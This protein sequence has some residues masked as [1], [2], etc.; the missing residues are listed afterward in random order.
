MDS[1]ESKLPRVLLLL[2]VLAA[3]SL[4]RAQGV[5][6]AAPQQSSPPDRPGANPYVPGRVLVKFHEE[7]LGALPLSGR[8]EAERQL[9]DATV[10]DLAGAGVVQSASLLPVSLFQSGDQPDQL[11]VAA[12]MPRLYR[13]DLASGQDVLAAAAAL[14]RD[15]A[16]EYAEPDYLA[17]PAGAPNDPLYGNQWSLGSSGIQT[18]PAWSVAPGTAEIVIA[19][20]DSGLDLTHPDLA[21][22]L[23]VNPGEVPGNGKDDDLDGFVDDVR[24]WNFTA[25]NGGNNDV[26][27][28]TAA[29][30]HGT[31]VAGIAAARTNNGLGMAGICGNCRLMPVKVMTAAGAVAYSDLAAG[32]IYATAKGARVVNVSLGGYAASRTLQ[33]AVANASSHNVVVVGAAGNDNRN[34]AYYPAAYSEVIAIAGIDQA[35][36]RLATSNY[37]IWVDVAAPAGNILSTARNGLYSPGSGTSL[38]APFAAG[39]AG[40]LLS[41][42]GT[43]TPAQVQLQMIRTATSIDN[44][45]PAY[46]GNLGRGRLNAAAALTAAR[47]LLIHGGYAANGASGG[48]PDP[49]SQVEIAVALRND[50]APAAGVNATLTTLDTQ[51]SILNGSAAFGTILTG[52]TITN[53]VPF[54]ISIAAA[55]GHRRPIRF[56][57]DVTGN[58]GA[59]ATT[60]GFTVTTSSDV[61]PAPSVISA[62]TQWAGNYT[63]LAQGD[64]RV[65][66]GVRLTIQPGA[67]V[68]FAGNYAL[69][70]DGTLVADGTGAQPIVM[71]AAGNGAWQGVLFGDTSV[72]AVAGTAGTYQSGSLLRHVQ[73]KGATNGILCSDATPYLSNLAGDAGIACTMGSTDLWLLDSQITGDVSA[74]GRSH[75]RRTTI[76]HG[77]LS[78]GGSSE[79][80]DTTAGRNISVGNNSTLQNSVSGEGMAIN[81]NGTI[82]ACTASG[83]VTLTDGSVLSSTVTTGD[84]GVNDGTVR[85]NTVT[86]GKITLGSGNCIDNWVQGGEITV[87]SGGLI[88]GNTV[89]NAPSI[90]ITTSGEPTIV[91]N[92]VI[93]SGGMGMY[94]RKGL[95]QGNLIVDSVDIG[96]RISNSARVISNTITGSSGLAALYAGGVYPPQ[97]EGNNLELNRSQYDL[98]NASASTLDAPRNWWGTTDT[99]TIMQ[100]IYDYEDSSDWGRV[101]FTPTLT[102]PVQAAPPYLRGVTMTPSGPARLET[103]AFDVEF[104]RPVDS[105]RIPSVQIWRDVWQVFSSTNTSL[106]T[107]AVLSVAVDSQGQKWFGHATGEISQLRVDKSWQ[108]YLQ[109]QQLGAINCIAIDAAGNK[110]FGGND[111]RYARLSAAGAWQTGVIPGQNPPVGQIS[112]I[113]FDGLGNVWFGESG[114]PAGG[115]HVLRAAGSWQSYT[116]ANSGLADSSVEALAVDQAGNKWFGTTATGHG[117]SEL[118]A[119][120]TWQV[121]GTLNSG[122][123]RNDISAILPDPSG[124]IWIGTAGGGISVMRD[125]GGW[126]TYHAGNSGLAS[127]RIT[128]MAVDSAGTRWFAT[129]DAG[130]SAMRSD[131][132]WQIYNSRNSGLLQPTVRSLAVEDA[133]TRW[134]A[135]GLGPVSKLLSTRYAVTENPGWLSNNHYRASYT[136]TALVTRGVYSLTVA[137]AGAL[138]GLL[139]A[140]QTVFTFTLDYPGG[141]ADPTP[142]GAPAVTARSDGSLTRLLASWTAYD[143]NTEITGYRYAIGTTPGGT[144]VVNWTDCTSNYLVRDGLTLIRS[145]PYYVTVRARNAGGVWSPAG[146]S[147]RVLAGYFHL[148]V[149]ILS[150]G[151]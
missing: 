91:G 73:V 102:G 43:W 79:V 127:D 6:A 39:L 108:I 119:D 111:H 140:P 117:L 69:K 136:F 59:Y 38:A 101:I 45:N 72:D 128:A 52:Q 30:G 44:L 70:V 31:Q 17:F 95:V 41:W 137:D 96:L 1:M 34:D 92:R 118:R 87:I 42:Q 51:V 123:A 76:S 151:R 56:K 32:I 64:V 88:Q 141:S 2:L 132:S 24:G 22:N 109:A 58:G 122:I 54:T 143:P 53:W 60:L 130:V 99:A 67:V 113:A 98:Y 93:G 66:P 4:A 107:D 139:I 46:A 84:I 106:A 100:R 134:F 47:P 131:G 150:M 116:L 7:A 144:E 146:T 57:L 26:Q 71:R 29:N 5:E 12:G 114:D 9:L 8:P 19:I 135:H 75:V 65:M 55:A 10:A 90:G 105:N 83:P 50:W 126:V 48:Q 89:L 16:V 33:D 49:G 149:P 23:W 120:G 15:P 110:W 35:G 74:N 27:D 3:L 104:S 103:V 28:D 138:N 40:L 63:Y 133:E 13:L 21:P 62:D 94:V 148:F 11:A 78:L 86:S 125:D 61:Q 129:A 124:N 77:A 25:A 147:N 37:G 112:V 14:A 20:V 145:V 80:L 18:E 142:P 121:F 97:L 85:A 81:G 82:E 68:E 36:Q 115:A